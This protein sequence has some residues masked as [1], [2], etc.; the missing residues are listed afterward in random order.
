MDLDQTG[1]RQPPAQTGIETGRAQRKSLRH[2]P[3]PA[4]QDRG[5]RFG[6]SILQSFGQNAF[7]LRDFAAQGKKGFLRPGGRRHGVHTAY[8][9]VMF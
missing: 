6:T 5:M 9:P 7:D 8:V 3:S 2:G 1:G 4:T